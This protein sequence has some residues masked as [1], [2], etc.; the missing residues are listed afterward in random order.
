MFRTIRCTAGYDLAFFRTHPLF[1]G[2]VGLF[3]F[4]P[5]LYAA[6]YLSSLWDPAS[7]TS[8]LT[9]IVVNGDEGADY[10]GTTVRL[11]AQLVRRLI[12]E[13]R[14]RYVEQ[15]DSLEARRQVDR[16]DAA[17]AVIIPPA[18]S[19]HAMDSA[20]V[21]N[22]RLIVHASEGNNYAGA[23]FARRF[24]PDV[25]Q[26]L[27]QALNEQRFA[28]ILQ[29]ASGSSD[30]LKQL[31]DA[32][33]QLTAG[34]TELTAGAGQAR[35]AAGE[36]IEGTTRLQNG[37][38]TLRDALDALDP[39]AHRL[40]HG[41]RQVGDGLRTL[42]AGVPAPEQL[43]RLVQGNKEIGAG[44]R[45]LVAGLLTLE[46]G[47]V[48]LRDGTEQ[49]G[50][51]GGR[52]PFAGRAIADGAAQLRAGAEQLRVGLVSAGE[53]S[54]RLADGNST[55]VGHLG[56]LTQGMA[57]LRGGLTRME[58]ALPGDG[59]LDA[60]SGG[61]SDA[62]KGAGV[63]VSGVDRLA[64]GE[65]Q[66]RQGLE[67][68]ASGSAQLRDGLIVMGQRLPGGAPSLRGSASGLSASVRADLEI[69]APVPNQG[70]GMA[71]NFAPLSLWVGA[72]LCTFLFAYGT[73]PEPL[74][75]APRLGVVLGKLVTPALI[76][77]GQAMVLLLVLRW[78]LD[79]QVADMGRF[80]VTL[81]LTALTFLCV[82]FMLV[83]VFGNIG[84]LLALFLLVTQLA[85]SGATLP[86]EL[87]S[88]FFQAIHP[89]LPLTWA[90]RAFRIAAFGA[91]EGAWLPSIAAIVASM[92]AAIALA[93]LSG[94][95]R[96]VDPA[97]Y[98]PLLE[99]KG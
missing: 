46:Q 51:E 93:T 33:A 45:A 7:H 21:G 14:F 32:V 65:A 2:A 16:G 83:R 94:R 99:Q 56:A 47:S 81:A 31:R 98:Q 23:G 48:Q 3:L 6:V 5:A 85:A 80:A 50:E 9:V 53:A 25:A 69:A 18:F 68:L 38:R 44:Q 42:R 92:V 76:V 72:T 66:L 22:A 79:I 86:I 41:F 71:P 8:N 62:A 1:A 37:T 17:F 90:V 59:S 97:E 60:F 54:Q 87:S 58:T 55:L 36:L 12:Q 26:S 39:G 63:L 67:R 4:I 13:P 95:W 52:I 74:R 96:V 77:L 75:A 88:P 27:N 35:A 28:L 43:D 20:A 29:A 10:N 11:G 19:R 15:S 82:L 70:S 89:W 91:Y 84:K 40:V 49:L 24:A 64:G 73:L 30:G 57:A 78:G 34:A 61:V